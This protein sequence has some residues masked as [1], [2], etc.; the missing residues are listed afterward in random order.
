[1]FEDLITSN[2]DK[3]VKGHVHRYKI[4]SLE[5]ISDN[6][7]GVIGKGAKLPEWDKEIKKLCTEIIDLYKYL[8]ENYGEE[9][10]EENLPI[11]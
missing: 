4:K 10:A 8:E 5:A 1:M 11:V 9:I 2:S 3:E 7:T 6:S